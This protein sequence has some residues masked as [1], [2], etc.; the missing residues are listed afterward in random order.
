VSSR[1]LLAT[2]VA[3]LV[4]CVAGPASA[5]VM[6]L[7][8]RGVAVEGVPPP[9]LDKATEAHI[10]VAIKQLGTELTPVPPFDAEGGAHC[11]FQPGP[12]RTAH[13][14]VEVVQPSDGARAERTADVPY[15]DA[16]DL[17]ESLALLVADMLQ[18]D[19]HEIAVP[20]PGP[21]PP[22]QHGRN[23]NGN[24]NGSGNANG[25]ASGNANGNQNGNANG[26]GNGSANGNGNAGGKLVKPRR[27]PAPSSLAVEVG[28]SVA[29]GF[30]GDPPL[31]GVLLR[32]IYGQGALR[33]GGLLSF[34]GGA[35][36]EGG[37]QLSFLRLVTGPRVGAGI[38]RGRIDFDVTAGPALLVIATDAHLTDATHTLATGAIAFGARLA[39]ILKRPLALVIGADAAIALQR[40][41]VVSGPNLLAQFDLGS[42]ELTIGLA[43]HR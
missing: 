32:G 25:N 11:T 20:K 43:Y 19:L 36:H 31:A 29:L 10:A 4:V 38:A 28:P 14:L 33:I 23:G 9:R 18:S 17:A 27:P 8:W 6:R 1:R 35:I 5:Q 16:E 40:E 3:W 22:A 26:N 7:H 13:C 41:Q 21:E 42:L 15:R 34:T 39:V 2:T 30:S 37:Y 12:P 24:G